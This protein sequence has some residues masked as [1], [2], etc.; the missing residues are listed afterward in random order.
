MSTEY[1]KET[2]SFRTFQQQLLKEG[3]TD[4]QI[5]RFAATKVPQWIIQYAAPRWTQ[6]ELEYLKNFYLNERRDGRK[7]SGAIYKQMQG[8]LWR[9]LNVTRPYRAIK[10]QIEKMKRTDPDFN[11]YKFQHWD[12]E[13]IVSTLEE[14][15]REG[16]PLNRIGV[17]PAQLQYQITNHSRPKCTTRNFEC[18]FHSFDRAVA[19]A[20]LNVGYERT[21]GHELDQSRPIES[22]EEALWYYRRKEKNAHAWSADEIVNLFRTAH[23]KGL[24][25]TINFFSKHADLYKDLLGVNRSLEG[26]RATVKRLMTTWG[27]LVMRAVPDYQNWYDEQGNALGTTGELR[28][29]RWLELNDIRYRIPT[30]AD[31]ITVTDRTLVEQG[32]K[33]FIPDFY[34]L[35]QDG[36]ELAI[37]EVFGSIADSGAA[38]GELSDSYLEKI[39]AKTKTFEAMPVDFIAI[40][41]NSLYGSDLSDTRLEEKFRRYLPTST[42]QKVAS[43][44]QFSHRRRTED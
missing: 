22:L 2:E 26:L 17:E 27:D 32:Y 12:R 34:V 15:Y 30:K 4:S 9:D 11:E 31:K 25:L 40:H 35:D 24:P 19:E 39:E 43:I 10:Q 1:N 37:V 3:F 33:N 44:K 13:K 16:K 28:I 14:A 20:I 6:R 7:D 21:A 8:G 38:D 18:W 5:C 23:E 29:K 41:D 42:E 36:R